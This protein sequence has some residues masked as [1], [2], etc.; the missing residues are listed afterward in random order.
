LIFL[1]CFSTPRCRV[2]GIVSAAEI[3]TYENTIYISGIEPNDDLIFFRQAQALIYKPSVTIHV[4][5]P[6]GSLL[7]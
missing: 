7:K 3:E 1:D 5:G 4:D 2:A 6:G